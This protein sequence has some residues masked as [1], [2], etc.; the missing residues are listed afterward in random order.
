MKLMT[1]VTGGRDLEQKV[2][3]ESPHWHDGFWRNFVVIRSQM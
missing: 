3:L 1:F 2:W